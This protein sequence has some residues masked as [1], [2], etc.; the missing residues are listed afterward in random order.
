[1]STSYKEPCRDRRRE[2]NTRLHPD[3]Y[4]CNNEDG[5]RYNRGQNREDY[6]LTS[7]VGSHNHDTTGRLNH[8]VALKDGYPSQPARSETRRNLQPVEHHHRH[9]RTIG[10]PDVGRRCHEAGHSASINHHATERAIERAISVAAGTAYR[11]RHDQGSWVGGKGA[12]VVGAAAAAAA[13]NGL[14]DPGPGE[15][16]LQEVVVT[17]IQKFVVGG[18]V[19][20]SVLGDI[21]H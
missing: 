6:A 11:V 7:K 2:R 3:Y 17:M 13:I 8:T 20:G 4:S 21:G 5:V 10:L 18:I 14:L 15:H 9:S 12:K 16:G 19:T 1:M